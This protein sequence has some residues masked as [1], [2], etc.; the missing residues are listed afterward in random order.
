MDAKDGPVPPSGA[1]GVTLDPAPEAGRRTVVGTAA[2]N[3]GRRG[4]GA[5]GPFRDERGAGGPPPAPVAPAPVAVEFLP[6]DRCLA[7]INKQ[8]RSTHLAYPLFGLAR[9]FLQ[10]P[11]RHLVQFTLTPEAVAAGA[12][13]YQLGEDGPVTLDRQTLEKN[14]VRRR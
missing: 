5:G 4:K 14:G 1:T 12:T 10:E 6:D 3:P 13:L 2:A 9:M 11:E 8:I 7:S